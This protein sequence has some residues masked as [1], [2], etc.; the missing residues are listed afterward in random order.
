MLPIPENVSDRFN[1]VLEKRAIHEPSRV[2]YGKWL[3]YFLDF[4]KKYSPPSDQSA[5]VRLFIEKLKSKK[6]SPQQCAQ[7]AHAVSLFFESQPTKTHPQPAPVPAEPSQP[8]GLSEQPPKA[9][10]IGGD[11]NASSGLVALG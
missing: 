9:Y 1:I 7:A 2:Y 4:C 8:I 5:Q 6:Q 10:L 11:V 3:R